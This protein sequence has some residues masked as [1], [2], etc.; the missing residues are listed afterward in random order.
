V[1]RT[2]EAVDL[3]SDFSQIVVPLLAAGHSQEVDRSDRR[4][5]LQ[6]SSR[7]DMRVAR[8]GV[9]GCSGRRIL[10]SRPETCLGL[11]LC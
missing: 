8:V 11:S 3:A 7:A 4:S 9:L 5:R 6:G 10:G 2:Q 1:L